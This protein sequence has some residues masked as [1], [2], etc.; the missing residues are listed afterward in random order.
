MIDLEI[1]VEA[2]DASA[3]VDGQRLAANEGRVVRGQEGDG[4]GDL[5]RPSRPPHRVDPLALLQVLDAR[6]RGHSRAMEQIGRLDHAGVDGVDPD[7]LRREVESGASGHLIHGGLGDLVGQSSGIGPEAS[8]ARH[9]DD[10]LDGGLF[11]VLDAELRQ[12]E[13]RLD[14]DVH[15]EVESVRGERFEAVDLHHTRVVHEDVDTCATV[16]ALVK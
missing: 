4:L 14:V 15:G 12:F 1:F 9:V 6:H 7:A 10:A 5:V 3:A 8:D 11:E 16:P 13:R 2:G